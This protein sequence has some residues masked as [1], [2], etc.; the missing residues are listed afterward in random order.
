MAAVSIRPFQFYDQQTQTLAVTAA[1]QA[2]T[3]TV[4]GLG[5]RTIRVVNSG[6]QTVFMRYNAAATVAASLPIL[7]NTVE[8]FVLPND[9]TTLNFI[10]AGAGSTVYVT[11][12]E[13]A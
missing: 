4:A 8:V 10:A 7:A 12:G 1:S 11:P 2:I 9:V 13:G 3:L 6:T 5:T